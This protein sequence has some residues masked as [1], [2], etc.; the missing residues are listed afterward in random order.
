[1]LRASLAKERA[2]A[3]KGRVVYERLGTV[4]AGLEWPPPNV[5]VDV[6]AD[7]T[8]ALVASRDI[9]AGEDFNLAA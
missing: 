9:P 5:E 6:E 1:M 7:L 2:P 8:A 3:W 4:Q